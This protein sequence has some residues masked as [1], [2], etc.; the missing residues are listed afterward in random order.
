MY[1][2]EIVMHNEPFF[3]LFAMIYI[4]V[5]YLLSDAIVAAIVW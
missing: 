2:L 3:Y 4:C 1:A 5:V